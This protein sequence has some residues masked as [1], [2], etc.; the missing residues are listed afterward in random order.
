MSRSLIISGF[1]FWQDPSGSWVEWSKGGTRTGWEAA[2]ALRSFR[3]D[4]R[5]FGPGGDSGN[6]NERSVSEYILK[7]EPEGCCRI[8][9]WIK[10]E[11][12]VALRFPWVYQ[13]EGQSCSKLRWAG[14][15]SRTSGGRTEL[16]FRQLEIER[17]VVQ[18]RHPQAPASAEFTGR[19]G[20]GHPRGHS[21]QP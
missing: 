19:L 14:R 7:V 13:L 4:V 21:R 18:G 5:G 16:G 2:E 6:G 8:C 17:T 10:R 9:W 3:G 11:P 15:G 1:T 20:E 12:R